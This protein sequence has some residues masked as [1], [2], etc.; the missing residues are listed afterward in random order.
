MSDEVR[1][2]KW[3][4]AVRLYKTRSQA[5]QAIKGGKIKCNGENVKP[6]RV[7]KIGEVYKVQHH[8]INKTIKVLELLH[9]RVAAKDVALYMEDLTPPE[10]SLSVKRWIE[11]PFVFRPRGIGRPTKRDRRK[12]DEIL[13]DDN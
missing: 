8:Q 2:D 3:L 6:S 10:E 12:I 9:N 13:D 7:V 11:K 4:W 5:T 1:I